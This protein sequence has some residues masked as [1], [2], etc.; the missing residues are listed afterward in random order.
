MDKLQLT[1]RN[2]SRVFN[3]RCGCVH[4]I[5]LCWYEVKLTSLRLKTQPKWLLCSPLV[6]IV[7]PVGAYPSGAHYGTSLKENAHSLALQVLNYDGSVWD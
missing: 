6:N 1:G 5:H 3:F 2:L 4:D 7:L